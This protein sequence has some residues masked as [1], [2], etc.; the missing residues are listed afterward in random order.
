MDRLTGRSPHGQAYLVNVKE[1]EQA[2]DGPYNTLKCIMECLNRL[3]EYEDTGYTPEQIKNMGESLQTIANI[4]KMVEV[5]GYGTV[6]SIPTVDSLKRF[7]QETLDSLSNT[8][9]AGR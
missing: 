7:A 3:A 2:V 4:G 8:V 9:A 6:I 1:H 5:K